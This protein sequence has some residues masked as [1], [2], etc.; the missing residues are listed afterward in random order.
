MAAITTV[1]AIAALVVAAGSAYV[2][3]KQNQKSA[4][5]QRQAAAT[6]Q[7]EQRAQQQAQTRQQVRQE[8]V[9]RAQI[10]QGAMNT[11]VTGSSG[12]LG[13]QSSLGS[14]I[15][16]NLA[17]LGRGGNSSNAISGFNQQAADASGRANTWTQIGG[18]ASSAS[19]MFASTPS[20]QADF[21]KMFGGTSTPKSI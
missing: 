1:L 9:R 13:A 6:S 10:I 7:A 17:N 21:N 4:R 2:S 19:G 5:F 8:R 20:A 18:I 3:Y 15:E 16:N 12:S 14:M 11:G